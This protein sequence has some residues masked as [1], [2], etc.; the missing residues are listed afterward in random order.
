M[1]HLNLMF[2]WLTETITAVFKT[3]YQ[4]DFPYDPQELFI[5][6]LVGWE[7]I[8]LNIFFCSFSVL[9]PWLLLYIDLLLDICL[10][11]AFGGLAGAFFVW[12]HRNYVLFM[13][14]NKKI[15]SFLQKKSVL[16]SYPI[17]SIIICTC[18]VEVL[19]SV[20]RWR[21][22]SAERCYLDGTEQDS[23]PDFFN[24]ILV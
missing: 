9:L 1:N 8:M 17:H 13:R 19:Q 12:C 23:W 6:A 21:L 18:K 24:L 11:S 16:P 10:R 2:F 5:Y 20:R 14:K 15:S 3:N 22:F 4:I 7:S